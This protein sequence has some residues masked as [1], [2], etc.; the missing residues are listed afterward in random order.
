MFDPFNTNVHVPVWLQI[1][2][3][4][5]GVTESTIVVMG[6]PVVWWVGFAAVI[7]LAV[8]ILSKIFSKRF[9]LKNSLPAI[10]IVVLFFFQWL[11][12]IL[13][14]RVVFIYHF[15]GNVPFLCLAPAFLIGKYWGNKWVKILSI[16]YFALTIFLF[17][18]FFPVISGVPTS[19]STVSGLRWFGSW[20]F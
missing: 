3:L 15:Y 17:V 7:A 9:N 12:Y 16:A 11:P 6:S 19:T 10:F 1:T 20:V 18:L 13:I 8:I 2:S 4:P 14:S 5:N